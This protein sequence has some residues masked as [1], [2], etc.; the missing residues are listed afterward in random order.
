[1]P[2]CTT[3]CTQ[4]ILYKGYHF[5]GDTKFHVFSRLFPGKTNEI[6]SQFSFESLINVDM[7]K[8]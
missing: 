8:M 6:Q 1:M 2:L 3:T 4:N 7:T 5:S